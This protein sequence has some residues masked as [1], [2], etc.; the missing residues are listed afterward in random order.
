[1]SPDFS[2]KAVCEGSFLHAVCQ[3]VKVPTSDIFAPKR[4]FSIQSLT[5]YVFEK[6]SHVLR[7]P[8]LVDTCSASQKGSSSFVITP[9]AIEFYEIA[10]MC[11]GV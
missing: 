2:V 5:C 10:K 3:G 7:I 1:M 8:I 4:Q 6:V 9:L 11:N